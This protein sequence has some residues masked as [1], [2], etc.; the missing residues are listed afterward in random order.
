MSK[1]PEFVLD[2]VFDAPPELVWRAWTDPT[3]LAQW[4]GPNVETV[5]H[6]FDLEPGGVWLNEMKMSQGSSYQKVVF[7]EIV[8]PE[9]LVWHHFSS[10]DADWNPVANP[11][12][13]DWP[14]LLLTTVTFAA[15]ADGGG[16]SVR[17]SQ[18]PL[19]AS[20]AEIACFAEMKD[21]MGGGWGAG[22]ALI[23]QLLAGMA[24]S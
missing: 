24:G 16:T 2:R 7:K 1:L 18:I 14:A 23:D 3:L 13:P 21:N 19:D 20:D 8:E 6:R 11:M 17:L 22:Y 9:K 5:I 12:M 10:V 15:V 4:D